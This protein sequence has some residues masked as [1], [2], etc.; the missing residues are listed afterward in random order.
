M[1]SL[2]LDW[3][4]YLSPVL[5]TKLEKERIVELFYQLQ[6]LVSLRTARAAA[7]S[8]ND[9]LRINF[10]EFVT[11]GKCWSTM[12]YI[13]TV[14]EKITFYQSMLQVA[15]KNGSTNIVK[16]LLK[17]GCTVDVADSCGK[18]PLIRAVEEK[19]LELAQILIQYHANP[20]SSTKNAVTPLHIATTNLD[21]EMCHL[22][23]Q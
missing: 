4:A 3:L 21:L 12:E 2:S 16:L 15:C 7:L 10:S 18:T 14:F 13:A 8:E 1:Q 5:P 6:S 23:L 17:G 22:L 19:N 9:K 20:C 11:G